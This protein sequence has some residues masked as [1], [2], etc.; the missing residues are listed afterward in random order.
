MSNDS[1]IPEN[2]ENTSTSNKRAQGRLFVKPFEELRQLGCSM[3]ELIHTMLRVNTAPENVRQEMAALTEHTKKL[4]QVLSDHA[5]NDATP[6]MSFNYDEGVRPYYVNTGLIGDH[7]PLAPVFDLQHADGITFGTV[8]FGVGYEGPPGCVHGGFVA[9]F[10]DQILSQHILEIHKPSM[11][12]TLSV[13]YIAPTP[14]MT[15]LQYTVRT[16]EIADSKVLVEGEIKAN[17]KLCCTSDAI[18]VRARS[19]NFLGKIRNELTNN[20]NKPV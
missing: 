7:N 11:T 5:L 18:F 14:I 15:D 4:Q 3:R 9:F 1:S 12:G 10:F 16:K 8:H 19:T 13:R 20:D 6:C 17:G 2:N